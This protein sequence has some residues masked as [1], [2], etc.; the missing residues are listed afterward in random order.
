MQLLC[1]SVVIGEAKA[2]TSTKAQSGKTFQP[3][4]HGNAESTKMF[5]F[6]HEQMARYL[7]VY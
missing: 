2:T 3:L 4:I 5:L 7:K 1:P 6:F